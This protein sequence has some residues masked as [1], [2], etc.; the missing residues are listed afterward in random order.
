VLEPA[1]AGLG[2]FG[3]GGE[4]RH[5]AVLLARDEARL[6]QEGLGLEVLTDDVLRRNVF[7][8][9]DARDL[10]HLD[11]FFTLDTLLRFLQAF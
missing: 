1:A 4:L 7:V 10:P 11:A 6:L 8:F 3:P 9:L 5:N 2:A